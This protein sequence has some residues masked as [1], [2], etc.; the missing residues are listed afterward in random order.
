GQPPVL[1]AV[2]SASANVSCNSGNNGSAT[3]S[4]NG[5]TPG[6]TYSWNT[7]PVQT[8]ATATNLPAG[9]YTVTV[10]DNN[11]CTDTAMVTIGQP[12]GLAATI[13]GVTNVPCNPGSTGSA[14]VIPTGGTAPYTYSW[15]TMPGQTTPTVTGWPAGLYTATVT[16]NNGCV[17]TASVSI[18]QPAS[19]LAA[20]ISSSANVS[21]NGGNDGTAIV[22]ATG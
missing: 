19:S 11:G 5:G 6:Y 1:N 7:V 14:T 8:T 20:T 15:N 21:C 18:T 12:N 13:T 22:T 16:D 2:I 9:T 17:T 4:A 10:T 3:A